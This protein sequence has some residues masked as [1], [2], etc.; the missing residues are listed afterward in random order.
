MLWQSKINAV[1]LC[2]VSLSC[3]A[4]FI[5]LKLSTIIL[6]VY[7]QCHFTECLYVEYHYAECCG[8][9]KL[10]LCIYAVSLFRV[11]ILI[12]L[13][14]NTVIL[15]AYVQCRFTECLY[16]EC[17]FAEC[18]GRVKFMLCI[19]AKCHYPVSLFLLT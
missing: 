11:T 2:Q 12:A 4:V 6:S 15:N 17:H 9:V 19:Y 18:C 3:V 1:H 5:D 8:R 14:L 13:M 7:V 16:V 10:M